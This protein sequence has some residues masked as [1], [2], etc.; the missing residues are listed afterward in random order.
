[1]P[2]ILKSTSPVDDTNRLGGVSQMNLLT[3]HDG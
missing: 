1:M 2:F 3:F